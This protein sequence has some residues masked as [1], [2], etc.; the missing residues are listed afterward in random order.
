MSAETVNQD[1]SG[2]AE[3]LLITLYLRAMESLRPDALVKDEKNEEDLWKQ[4]PIS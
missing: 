4:D 1:V 3:K 2:V